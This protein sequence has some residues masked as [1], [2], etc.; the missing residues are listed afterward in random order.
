MTDKETILQ[1]LEDIEKSFKSIKQHV[2]N[3]EKSFEELKLL[4]EQVGVFR[5]F[6]FQMSGL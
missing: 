5:I 6:K 1:K 3:I 4:C 2:N